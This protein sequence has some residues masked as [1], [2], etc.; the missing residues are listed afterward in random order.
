[1]SEVFSQPRIKQLPD[2]VACKIAAGEVVERPASVLKELLE[3]SIDAGASNIEVQLE[4]GGLKAIVV[5]DNG[6]GI[7]KQDLMLATKQHATS[8]ISNAE[9]LDCIESLGFRGEALASI[10]SIARINITT[11]TLTQEHAWQLL[12]N[13]VTP[14]SHPVGTT[15]CVKDIFYNLPARRKFLR[16][17]RTEYIYLE[18]IFRRI[19]LS[20]FNVS[21][22][23]SHN[24]KLIKN[25]PRSQ[26]LN[27]QIQRMQNVCGKQNMQ[28]A[29]KIDATQNG[30]RLWGWLGNTENAKSNESHQYF[31]INQRII[32]DRLINHAIREAYEPSSLTGKMPFYCL[33]LE[34]DPLSLDVNVHPTKY[35]VRFRE[36]RIIHAFIM[37]TLKEALGYSDYQESS[38]NPQISGKQDRLMPQVA[39]DSKAQVLTILQH[40]LVIA[41]HLDAIIL[42]DVATIRRELLL[43]KLRTDIGVS[44]SVPIAINLVTETNIADKFIKW[45]LNFNIEFA[46]LGPLKVVIRTMPKVLTEMQVDFLQLFTILQRQWQKESSS[47]EVMPLIADCVKYKQ[48][49][50]SAAKQLLDAIIGIEHYSYKTL[51]YEDFAQNIL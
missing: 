49:E 10:N 34:L 21:F 16:S 11:Q 36:S 48:I 19:V 42:F 51:Q 39:E 12:D 31:Y 27:G 8:K 33:F 13:Q 26:D 50:I 2:D 45:C 6:C 47:K 4:K 15:I 30:M 37:D 3:N 43:N 7:L 40:K 41:K 28:H 23:L 35:E 24:G 22:K 1:M 32:K 17:E 5:N 9:S 44:L 25:L 29:L 18:E 38:Y 20:N 46:S 14:A